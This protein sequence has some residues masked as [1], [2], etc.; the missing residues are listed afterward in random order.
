MLFFCLKHAPLVPHI[1]LPRRLALVEV[2]V[3]PEALLQG[4]DPAAYPDAALVLR[5]P[6]MPE[7]LKARRGGLFGG[8]QEAL[9]EILPSRSQ[10]TTA[11]QAGPAQHRIPPVLPTPL[12]GQ[13]PL[14]PPADG[15]PQIEVTVWEWTGMAA[16]APSLP[17]SSA[18]TCV[19]SLRPAT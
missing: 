17:H 4:A 8:S 10:L 7:E 12:P 6:G 9:A 13:V 14:A 3:V 19:Q 2:A 5:A 16:G 15:K 11:L 1:A 18:H